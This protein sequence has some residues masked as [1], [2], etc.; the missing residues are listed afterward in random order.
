MVVLD[1][2]WLPITVAYVLILTF[3]LAFG[4]NLLYLTLVAITR[5]PRHTEPVELTTFPIVT[6]QLPIYNEM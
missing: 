4:T 3:F 2:L 6:V 1:V 5:A